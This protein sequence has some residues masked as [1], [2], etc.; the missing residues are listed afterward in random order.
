ITEDSRYLIFK[1]KP[2]FKD[3]R[4]AKI[5]KK[6]IDDF[7]KDSIAIIE[8]GKEEF[9]KSPGVKSYKTPQKSYGW[10]AYQL[11]KNPE[12]PVKNKTAGPVINNNISD[13]LKHIVDSLQNII[14]TI[15]ASKKKKNK[16]DEEESSGYADAEGDDAGNTFVDTGSDLVVKNLES[17]VEKI[18]LNVL[19]YYFS[20]AGGKLLIE[21]ARN[22]KDSLSKPTVLLYYLVDGKSTVLSSG[23][24]DFKNF[25]MTDDGSQ[26]AYVAERDAKPKELQKFYKLWYYK[27]GM[28]SAML[29]ADKFSVGMKLGMTISEY[30]NLSFSK[31]G[32]RLFFG[33]APIQTPKDTTLV[34]F[35]HAKVDIWNYKDDYLQTVQN[36][37]ARLRAA[38][39]EN[40]LAICNLETKTIKQLGS[41]EIPQVLQTN[42]GD[43]DT[44]VGV[45]DFGKRIEGQWQGYT[46]KDI[47]SI[48]VNTGK[49]KLVK[50]NLFGQVYPSSTGKYIMWYDRKAR[51]YFAWDGST[52]RNITAKIK[53]PLYNEEYDMPDDP[54]NYGVMGWH[55]GD[56]AVYVYDR[57]DVWAI[58]MNN[59]KNVRN[60]TIAGR[61]LKDVCRQIRVNQD[62]RFVTYKQ[63]LYYSCQNQLSKESS[64]RVGTVSDNSPLLFT[65]TGGNFNYA[66]LAKAKES[67][68]LIYTRENFELTPD[69]IV[70]DD[71]LENKDLNE[72]M[73]RAIHEIKL[74]SINPQQSNYL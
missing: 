34:E 52:T 64:I 72:G 62:D 33:T 6:R 4:E 17:G 24:N 53:I 40:F 19:E 49:K 41:K 18:F 28:D 46:L 56:S 14:S 27:V 39:Q 30:G 3:T 1:I 48:D 5:K 55:E 37:P 35:E 20:K 63:L 70:N 45:S 61:G 16:D 32:K 68:Q 31:N 36:F 69:I 38:R 65:I 7:P 43:G 10:V 25:A 15:S 12:Q 47:Y 11:E 23:G 51:N 57:Y 54:T 74:S 67:K 60:V 42:E 58:D 22:P 59:E 26:V 44:F 50:E 71:E 13:S 73:R 21:L 9:W 66:M 8:L 29:L 2:F